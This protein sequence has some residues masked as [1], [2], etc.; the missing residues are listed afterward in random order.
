MILEQIFCKHLWGTAGNILFTFSPDGKI[1]S[2]EDHFHIRC[3]KCG[4]ICRNYRKYYRRIYMDKRTDRGYLYIKADNPY[5][6]GILG[7]DIKLTFK[8]KIDIFFS[9]GICV[10]LRGNDVKKKK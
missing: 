9:K 6:N 2:E 5:V 1:I 8:Q 10:L 4:K 7:T 3:K